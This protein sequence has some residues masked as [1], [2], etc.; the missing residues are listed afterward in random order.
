RRRQS[1][2]AGAKR[3]GRAMTRLRTR[4]EAFWLLPDRRSV[5]YGHARFG[6]R[7]R[8]RNDALRSNEQRRVA[9]TRIPTGFV[10][11]MDF[12]RIPTGFVLLFCLGLALG[13]VPAC[14][15]VP[16]GAAAPGTGGNGPVAPDPNGATPATPAPTVSTCHPEVAFHGAPI[17]AAADQWT[18]VP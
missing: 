15:G 14:A 5:T 17:D 7:A 18:W 2:S 6:R 16:G 4:N 11:A 1:T 12:V 8:P 9:M 13:T 3:S 10:L